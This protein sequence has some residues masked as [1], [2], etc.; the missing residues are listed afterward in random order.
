MVGMA[1]EERKSSGAVDGEMQNNGWK[2]DRMVEEVRNKGWKGGSCEVGNP[3]R[4]WIE[5]G[6]SLGTRPYGIG[7]DQ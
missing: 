4:S 5:H 6:G 3:E 1:E 2:G 7:A